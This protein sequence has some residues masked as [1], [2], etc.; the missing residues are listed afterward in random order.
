MTPKAWSELCLVKG[1]AAVYVVPMMLWLHDFLLARPLLVLFLVI[2]LG[3]LL[4]ELKFPGNF[5]FGVAAVLFV[6]L[7]FGAWDPSFQL[8]EIIPTLG[9]VLFVYCMGLEAAPGFFRALRKDGLRANLAVLCSLI[10]AAGVAVLLWMISG[11]PMELIV[12]VFSGAVTNTAALGSATELVQAQGRPVEAVNHLVV[13]YGVVYPISL[14]AALMLLQIRLMHLPKPVAETSTASA[15]IPPRT[16]FVTQLDAE[17]KPYTALTAHEST[18]L[19]FSRY[20]RTDGTIDLAHPESVFSP[21]TLVIAVGD[22]KAWEAGFER[23]GQMAEVPLEN[24]LDGFRVH[25]YFVSRREVVGKRLGDLGLEKLGATLSRVRRGDIDLPVSPETILQLGDRVRVISYRETEPQVRKF[26][27]NSLQLLTEHGYISFGLGIFLGLALGAIPWPI[28]GLSEPLRLGSAGGALFVALILGYLGRTGPF[29]WNI[30]YS[31]NLTLRQ[32]GLLLFLAAVGLRAG[33]GVPLALAEDGL[34]LI[35]SGLGLTIT[36]YG[37]LWLVL[38]W[39]REPSAVSVLGISCGMQTQPAALA[40]AAA[41]VLVM[42]LNIAYALVYPFA[43]ILKVVL[44][45]VL[46]LFGTGS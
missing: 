45:Q 32:L 41:R 6:G 38:H 1:E 21:G 16:L 42:P 44:V 33:G 12:G 4:G 43:L 31:A 26:F 19:V 30:P 46:L 25:R 40:F 39:L 22:E 18:G 20:R 14:L 36:T 5:R 29:I 7:F 2:A 17:G 27:G 9:L 15:L 3:Y 37:V 24:N 10:A 13:G 28:P 34:F 35:L 8:P 11:R 23:L